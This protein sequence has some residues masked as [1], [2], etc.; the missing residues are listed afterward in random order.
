MSEHADLSIDVDAKND[1]LPGFWNFILFL[2]V[3]VAGTGNAQKATEMIIGV[4]SKD[5][6]KEIGPY[7]QTHYI[8]VLNFSEF[9]QVVAT[10]FV[11][12]NLGKWLLSVIKFFRKYFAAKKKKAET[13]QPD[14]KPSIMGGSG[15]G[16]PEE[17]VE[18][19]E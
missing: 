9:C 13:K 6:A 19:D 7:L 8:G 14:P 12:I 5:A 4:V 16:G 2:L 18:K 15:G 17:E 11:L 3:T 10:L 1:L